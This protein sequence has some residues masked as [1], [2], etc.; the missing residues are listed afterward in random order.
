MGLVGEDTL[1]MKSNYISQSIFLLQFFNTGILL[2]LG[3]A[4]FKEQGISG[5]DGN[6]SDFGMLWYS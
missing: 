6:R 1:S 3:D 5:L 4:N 2:L